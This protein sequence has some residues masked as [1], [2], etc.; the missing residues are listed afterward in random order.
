MNS[1]ESNAITVVLTVIAIEIAKNNPILI[2]NV[3]ALNIVIVIL[4]LIQKKSILDMY[5]PL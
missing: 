3:I 5:C 2:G 4:I 1:S